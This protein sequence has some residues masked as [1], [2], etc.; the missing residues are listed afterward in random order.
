MLET[1][2]IPIAA[3]SKDLLLQVG[4]SIGMFATVFLFVKALLS[5][6]GKPVVSPQREAALATGHSDRRTL[7]EKPATRLLM[8]PLLAMAH[9]LAAPRFKA[10]LQ[11]TLVSA[12]SPEYYT[13]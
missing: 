3:I 1:S 9:R 5:H 4:I 10:K 7:F 2:A 8:W 11:A 13:A 12:G 6:P